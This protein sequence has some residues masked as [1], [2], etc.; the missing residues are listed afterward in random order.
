MGVESDIRIKELIDMVLENIR[1]GLSA[2]DNRLVRLEREVIEQGK[3][4]ENITTRLISVENKIDGALGPPASRLSRLR[5]TQEATK[6]RTDAS[7]DHPLWYEVLP[8]RLIIF[9]IQG[10]LLLI[11]ISIG[12]AN[13][14][15]IER[16]S[17]LFFNST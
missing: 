15:D 17:R 8:W 2:L 14:E 10:I 4:L 9:G 5:S 12:L 6:E 3:Q 7:S 13:I 1:G 11:M 16:L